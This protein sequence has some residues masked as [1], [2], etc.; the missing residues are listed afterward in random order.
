MNVCVWGGGEAIAV[1]FD[2]AM[3]NFELDRSKHT[4]K[5][6]EQHAEHPPCCGS[7]SSRADLL[8]AP[9]IKIITGFLAEVK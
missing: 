8:K 6:A 5:H 7:F 4:N 2:R 1:L 3:F 9:S